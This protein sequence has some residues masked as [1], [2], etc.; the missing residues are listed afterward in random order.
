M[1]A[2]WLA[3]TFGE[4]FKLKSGEML[5]AKMMEENGQYPVYGGNG[6]SGRYHKFNLQG[7]NV[8]IGRVGALCG[9]VR[10]LK[11]NIWLTD[12]AFQ[13]VDYKYD[14]DHAFLTYLLNFKNLRSFA[15][16]SAQPV[17]SNS[18]LR[19]VV[20][21]FPKFISEQQRIVSILDESLAAID[22]ARANLQ[23]NF[24]NTKELFQI[25]LNAI[26]SK[27]EGWI[28]KSL[29]EVCETKPPKKEAREILRDDDLVT[30]L[31]MED[32]SVEARHIKPRRER[33]LKEV[34]G[35]YTYFADGDVLLAKITPCFENGKIGIA[36]NLKNGIGFGSSEYMVFRS[37]GEVD[38]ELLYY[39]LSRKSFREEGAPRMTGAV[40]HKRVAKDWIENYPI[41]FPTALDEQQRIVR[42]LSGL[43]IKLKK[44]GILY[45]RKLSELEALKKSILE[46]AFSGE[47]T[48][49][50]LVN[51]AAA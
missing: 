8:I 19:N 41:Q 35:S 20:L 1:K 10:H 16:Q 7:S 33:M 2:G 38:R 32:L 30:F 4:C 6:I 40:G 23:K 50:V 37:K 28:E 36:C 17:I 18:S 34:A 9:N 27:R 22:N 11:E 24:S 51:E 13:I 49:P 15:R 48:N 29:N 14:F 5:T 39:F 47:L 42:K 31:P 43:E 45:E 26:F 25:E 3:K 21:A 12:N 44:L 46:K